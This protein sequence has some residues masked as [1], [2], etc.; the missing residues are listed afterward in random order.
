MSEDA[1]STTL[2]QRAEALFAEAVA[3]PEAARASFLA[4]LGDPALA[5]MVGRLLAADSRAG[6]FL[7]EAVAAGARA[8]VGG[9]AERR[10][11]ERIG[12]YRLLRL[13]GTGGAGAVYLAER[14]DA[15]FRQEVAIKLV[16]WGSDHGALLRRLRAE[17][18]I[19]ARLEHPNIARLL[20]G[21]STDDGQPFLVMER[22]EGAAI[23]RYCDEARR[24]L[25]E[26]VRLFQQVCAAVHYAHRNLVVHRDLKPSN[27]LVTAGGVPKLLDFGIAKLLAPELFAETV[28]LTA[29]LERPMTP[30]Y[31]SPEQLQGGAVT[32]ASDV[33]SLGVLLYELLAGRRPFHEAEG[34]PRELERA[35]CEREPLPPSAAVVAGERTTERAASRGERPETLARRLAGDLDNIV[36]MA[37]RKEPARRYGS[38]EQLAEDLQRYLEGRP[39]IAR[40][41][42]VTYRLKK[43]ARRHRAGV[44]VSSLAIVAGV[45]FMLNLAVQR[46]R[47]A[48]ERDRA[49]Q[50]S[51]LLVDL[52]SIAGPGDGPNLTAQYLLDRGAERV[53]Q[54][55]AQPETQAMLLETLAGLYEGMGLYPEAQHLLDRVLS[56]RLATAGEGS[57]AVASVQFDLGRLAAQRGDYRA[58]EKQF[59]ASLE[60]WR[61]LYGAES[62]QVGRALNAL[63]LAV[64]DLGDFAGAERY[65]REAAAIDL[66]LLGEKQ[67][68]TLVVRGNLALLLADVGRLAEA[69]RLFSELA[70]AARSLPPPTGDELRASNL[71]GLGMARTE[72]GDGRGAEE[73]LR[74]AVRLREQIFGSQHPLV[75]RSRNHLGRALLEEGDLTA[76]EGELTAA[77]DLRQRLLGDGH[78]ELAE[79]FEDL[80]VLAAARGDLAGAERLLRQAVSW[81]ETS[82]GAA[83]AITARAVGELG[84]VLASAGRCDEARG[85]L[86]RAL[87]DLPKALDRRRAELARAAA[88][89]PPRDG[90]Q[91]GESSPR[92]G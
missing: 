5:S 81:D 46:Q 29:H 28:A 8:V 44:T 45:A 60:R 37:L 48:R 78:S 39:V 17:R 55:E 10:E 34:S 2:W 22:I 90:G 69:E 66:R 65:Y 14:A 13:L 72:L 79:S 51:S 11:G 68:Q 87:G 20:D 4:A 21:G 84:Q 82:L 9:A 36:L 73:A 92:S 70:E 50:V 30:A 52:F 41:D 83:H 74:E 26:R 42:T 56:L 89:C 88:A 57:A 25:A 31:A 19:L 85:L 6:Q 1:G 12:P 24:S 40:P 76:A 33:Y 7:E 63:G 3:L 62:V 15:D 80:G 61:E 58:A 47:I 77:R 91:L 71:D 18:Q 64:H 27:V 35:I 75:A 67:R 32:T 38:A 43:F 49:E 86:D 16:R 53:L 59:R 23:D 54:L